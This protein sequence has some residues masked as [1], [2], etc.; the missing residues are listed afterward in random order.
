VSLASGIDLPIRGLSPELR[1]ATLLQPSHDRRHS[2]VLARG[3]IWKTHVVAGRRPDQVTV[4]LG[5]DA[6]K[7]LVWSWRTEARTGRSIVRFRAAVKGLAPTDASVVEVR[8]DSRTVEVPELLNDPVIRRHTVKVTGLEPDTPYAYSV[9]DGTAGGM[10]PW[11]VVRTG[12]RRS[13][14]VHLLAMG[15]PQCGLEGW[16]KLLAEAS[17]RHPEAG[18]LLI[19]GDLVD[20]GNERSNWDHFF[21]RASGVFDRLPVMPA[22]G[23]HEYLDK[24][25]RLYQSFFRLPA[26]GPEGVEPG[27]VYAFEYGDAFVGVL[28]STLAV[29]SPVEAKRQAEWLEDRLARTD[30][31]WKLVMFHHP[32]YASHRSR[33]NLNLREAWVPVFDRQGV[34]VVLQGHDHAYLRTY[35]MRAGR[36]VS[37]PAEGT[38]YVVSVSGDKY[39]D[40]DPR[41]YSEAAFTRVS[42]YQTIDITSE[43]GRLLYRSWNASGAEVD[44]F[45]IVKRADSSR[46]AEHL[47][48]SRR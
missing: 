7:E 26:N 38:T 25:P 8:G 21:L 28:D 13:A 9:G 5:A 31:R 45:E 47:P 20:R 32:V 29:C 6:S 16:G 15:D 12:P 35:P 37:T 44:R 1:G 4:A 30:R 22:V 40:Q 24:G 10:S 43:T 18:A 34:D 41:D 11:A 36:R 27:L 3:R 17:R 19:A 48:P 23:N 14:D 2:T 42:T 33:E 39:Y 46:L